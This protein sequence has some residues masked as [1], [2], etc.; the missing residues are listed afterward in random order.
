MP[1]PCTIDGCKK[2]YHAKG[3][4]KNHYEHYNPSPTIAAK[5][6][7][8][9]AAK[10]SSGCCDCGYKENAAA[11]QYDH[12][13]PTTKTRTVAGLTRSAWTVLIN[14]MAKCRVVCANCHNIHHHGF[15]YD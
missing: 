10:L 14:E 15:R 7:F 8:V 1:K 9:T 3:F 4:C 6:A 2:E 12:I 5:H 11:L 13:N